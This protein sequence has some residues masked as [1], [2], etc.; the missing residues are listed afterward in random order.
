MRK[1]QEYSETRRLFSPHENVRKPERSWRVTRFSHPMNSKE[2]FR[3]ERKKC[4]IEKV[5]KYEKVLHQMKNV[6]SHRVSDFVPIV[7]NRKDWMQLCRI[8]YE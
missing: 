1:I 6:L 3:T 8:F 7:T 5:K 2:D 4:K